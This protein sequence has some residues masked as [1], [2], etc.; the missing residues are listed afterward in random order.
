M[1]TANRWVNRAEIPT[2]NRLNVDGESSSVSSLLSGAM[3]TATRSVNRREI[4]SDC[5][6]DSSYR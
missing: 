2:V 3:T 6:G 5:D 1:T 4:P